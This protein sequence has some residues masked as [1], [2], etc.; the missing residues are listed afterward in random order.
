MH[1]KMNT[2]ETI[3]R[4]GGSGMSGNALCLTGDG[5]HWGVHPDD[6]TGT[7]PA[8]TCPRCIALK[9]H[10]SPRERDKIHWGEPRPTPAPAPVFHEPILE[11]R[12]D[13]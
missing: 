11:I 10:I 1:Y 2:Q 7:P 5:H 4:I 3:Q 12:N 13:H 8:I 9:D 6:W